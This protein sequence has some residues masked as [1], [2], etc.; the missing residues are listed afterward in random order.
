MAGSYSRIVEFDA[1]ASTPVCVELPA[2]PRGLLRRFVIKQVSGTSA[3]GSFTLYDRK[4]ACSQAT[5]LNVKESGTV[6]SVANEGG[7]AKITF[8]ASTGLQVGDTI[9][10]KGNSVADYNTT[11]TIT[12]KVSDSVFVSDVSYTSA[13][14]NG[15]WQTSPFMQT[16]APL[17]HVVFTD[18]VSSGEFSKYDIYIGFENRDNQSETKRTRYQALWLEF[19]PSQTG[20]FQA[21]ITTEADSAVL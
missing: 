11:H 21:A 18:N 2:V 16:Y 19:T 6:T 20:T 13:G 5:D 7:N 15:L 8:G 10:I 17:A 9:E 14:S 1:T 4:G 12:A 3:N